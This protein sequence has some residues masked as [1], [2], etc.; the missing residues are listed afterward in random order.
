[1]NTAARLVFSSSRYDRIT[2]L[3]CQLHWMRAPER[4]QVKLA[5]LVCKCLHGTVLSYLADELE[6]TADFEARGRLRSASSLSLNVRRTRLS[7]VGDQAFPVAAA[8]T[9]KSLPKH[10]TSRPHSL[11]LFSEVASRLSSSGVPSNDFYRTFCSAC[12]VTVVIFGHLNPSFYLPTYLLIYSAV[13]V[14]KALRG[15]ALVVQGHHRRMLPSN[16]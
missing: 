13:A 7:T 14:E 15:L 4:I 2:P 16:M 12:A 5:V 10:V 9:W 6:Y 1:M 8:R 11:C 3:L